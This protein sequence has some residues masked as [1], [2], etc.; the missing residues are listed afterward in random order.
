MQE[1]ERLYEIDYTE[2][3]FEDVQAHKKAGQ[4]SILT[5]IDALIDELRV[6]PTTGTGKP[7]PLKGNLKGQ[8]SRRITQKHRLIYKIDNNIVTVIL[9]A[10]FGHYE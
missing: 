7:E 6:H 3:F 10:A 4:K 8:W 1:T 9:F 2:R 5:K